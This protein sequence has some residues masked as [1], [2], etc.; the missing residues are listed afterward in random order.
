M[1]VLHISFYGWANDGFISLKVARV[2]TDI[3]WVF[4]V[5][6]GHEVIS[7]VCK[8]WA[9]ET[10]VVSKVVCCLAGLSLIDKAPLNHKD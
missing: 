10:E 1:L 5:H 6:Y 9:L 8:F 4:L 7:W 3:S 2:A